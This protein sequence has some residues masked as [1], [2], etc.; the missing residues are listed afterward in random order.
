M[1]KV[2]V[3]GY[4]EVIGE[5][6]AVLRREAGKPRYRGRVRRCRRQP[7]GDWRHPCD[8]RRRR[9]FPV[10][11]RTGQ[12]RVIASEP[13]DAD[14]TDSTPAWSPDW[15]AD[16]SSRGNCATRPSRC[17]A[18]TALQIDRASHTG[19]ARPD[20]RRALFMQADAVTVTWDLFMLNLPRASSGV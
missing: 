6:I 15:G 5:L 11:L 4:P 16:R 17:G 18:H 20:G 10:S 12:V 14:I 8:C 9:H 7:D 3:L 13:S 2:V 19:N 1:R